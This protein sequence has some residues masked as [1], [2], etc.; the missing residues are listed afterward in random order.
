MGFSPFFANKGYHPR[1]QVKTDLELTVDVVKPL[2][3]KLEN[4]HKELKRNIIKVQV[5]YQISTDT[6]WSFPPKIQVE[7]EVFILAK[8][9]CITRPSKK[10]LEKYL[11]S[12]IVSRKPGS[13]LY[14]VNLPVHLKS[15]YS[16]FHV[17]Q[18]EPVKLSTVQGYRNLP[19]H[20]LKSKT[21][22]NLKSFKY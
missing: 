7:D 17:S 18:P 11:D 10:L 9:I 21:T 14:Q 6:Q 12:F 4:I 13:Y 3:S 15:I 20:W 22:S 1:L 19:L 8:F 2:L 16:V 5:H